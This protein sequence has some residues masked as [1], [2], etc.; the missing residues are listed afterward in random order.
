[1]NMGFKLVIVRSTNSKH[2]ATILKWGVLIHVLYG[3]CPNKRNFMRLGSEVS[4]TCNIFVISCKITPPPSMPLQA[5]PSM[6]E[7]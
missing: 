7:H 5:L 2:N 6:P 4:V 3:H 1:M